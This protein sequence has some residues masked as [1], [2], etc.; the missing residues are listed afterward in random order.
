MDHLTYECQRLQKA[1]D[2][3]I[4]SITKQ[5][6]WPREKSDLVNEYIKQFTQFINSIDFDKM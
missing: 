6:T 5:D 3:L 4:R 2:A 1:T